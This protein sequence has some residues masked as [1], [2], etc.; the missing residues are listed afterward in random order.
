MVPSMVHTFLQCPALINLALPTMLIQT[1]QHLTTLDSARLEQLLIGTI[2]YHPRVYLIC[3]PYF[4][5][6]A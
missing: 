4:G 5:L 6:P 3:Y 1:R 2:W